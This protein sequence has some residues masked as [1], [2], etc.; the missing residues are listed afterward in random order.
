M[1]TGRRLLRVLRLLVLVPT[2]MAGVGF[3]CLALAGPRDL[4]LRAWA[5]A[6]AWALG[7]RV[8]RC[9][10]KP[11]PGCLVV[12]NHVGYLDILALG[13]VLPG[14]FLAKSEIAGWPLLGFLA[15]SGGSL[16]VERERP[17]AIRPAIDEVVARLE[18][19]GR[20]L[21]F[22]EAGV[23]GDGTTLGEF[24]PMLFE[25]SVLSGRPV[26]PVAVRY[27]A[28][29]DPRVWAWIEEPDLWRHL[30]GRVLPAGSIHVEVRVGDPI[31]PGPG[32]DRKSLAR[33]AR[34]AV[35]ELLSHAP[36]SLPCEGGSP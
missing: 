10:A 25:S 29:A 16:F 13:R 18:R 27:T 30:W 6:T 22:P 31:A 17:R 3:G 14:S 5:G 2:A 33:R 35:Q 26:L 11:P 4:A 34:D 23:E 28:P 8:R 19:G 32:E 1:T 36:G 20:V 15:R 21:L 24:R 12:S 9:G 7:L